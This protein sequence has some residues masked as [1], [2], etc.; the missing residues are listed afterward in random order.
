MTN[1]IPRN[2]SPIYTECEEY[3]VEYCQPRRT[4]L[5]SICLARY[6]F[7][8]IHVVSP[9]LNIDLII[10]V[11]PCENIWAL[12]VDNVIIILSHINW[13]LSKF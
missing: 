5:C 3:F 6:Y 8:I 9:T 13:I 12:K 2:V 11:I 10:C 1:N 4:L 7:Q